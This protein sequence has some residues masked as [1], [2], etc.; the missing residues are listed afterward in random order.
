MAGAH[1]H[2]QLAVGFEPTDARTVSSAWIDD[3]ERPLL[4][5]DCN[6]HR[7]LDAGEQI[8]GWSLERAGVENQLG[9]EAEHMRHC[10]RPMLGIV[11]AAPAQYVPKQDRA[12]HRIRQ[13]IAAWIGKWP[14]TGR[15]RG[16]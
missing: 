6:P 10:H 1:G 16:R 7:R 15:C 2:T 5:V 11:V 13:I 9:V 4:G 14:R 3:Y 8:I 12:L